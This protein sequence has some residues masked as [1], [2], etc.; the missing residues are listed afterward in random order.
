VRRPQGRFATAPSR[1]R[2]V[3]ALWSASSIL[4][5]WVYEPFAADQ[6]FSFSYQWDTSNY[7]PDRW[8]CGTRT[9]TPG[10]SKRAVSLF[11]SPTPPM[12]LRP[13]TQ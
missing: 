9:P 12:V 8:P 2:Q 3:V 7:P 6:P 10:F 1:D 5:F 4:G 13:R 11:P